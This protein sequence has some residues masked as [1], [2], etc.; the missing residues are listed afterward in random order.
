M[1]KRRGICL[2]EGQFKPQDSQIWKSICSCLNSPLIHA[3]WRVGNGSNISVIHKVWFLTK[4]TPSLL[5]QLSVHKVFQTSLNH[6]TKTWNSQL[7][8][9]IY[10]FEDAKATSFIP[11][12]KT[13]RDDMFIW[14]QYNREVYKVKSRYQLLA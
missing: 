4:I 2:T 3:K 5:Q 6:E 1:A 9:Q 8:N 13:D 10:E 14:S 12:A 11:I 7:L